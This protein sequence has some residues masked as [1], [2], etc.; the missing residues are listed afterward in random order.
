[1]F[2][3]EKLLSFLHILCVVNFL[4]YIKGPYRL[5]VSS[6]YYSIFFFWGKWFVLIL[7]V[8]FCHMYDGSIIPYFSLRPVKLAGLT[9]L[10]QNMKVDCMNSRKGICHDDVNAGHVPL[11]KGCEFE[12]VLNSPNDDLVLLVTLPVK[13]IQLRASFTIALSSCEI[14][15]LR[16]LF[17]SCQNSKHIIKMNILASIHL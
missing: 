8:Q 4:N 15:I 2:K 3:M 13:H 1:M 17:I 11:P 12:M 16:Y 14:K 9:N 5:G 7:K 10:N 6:L